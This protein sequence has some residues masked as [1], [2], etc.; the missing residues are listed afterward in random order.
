M[1]GDKISATVASLRVIGEV[2]ATPAGNVFFRV[3]SLNSDAK[4]WSQSAYIVINQRELRDLIVEL[5]GLERA[6]S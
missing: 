4:T 2:G 6:P 1:Y 3:G 5:S